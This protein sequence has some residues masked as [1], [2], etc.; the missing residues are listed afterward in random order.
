M[1]EESIEQKAI[2]Y[3]TMRHIEGVR[4][5]IGL[6]VTELLKRAK[7][8]DQE[9]MREPEVGI[10]TLYT[11]KLKGSTYGSPEYK[12]YLREM[13]VALDHHYATYRHHPEFH[14]DCS[15]VPCPV[16]A[17]YEIS[18]SG[19]IRTADTKT[20]RKLEVTPHGYC[21]VQLRNDKNYLVHRLVMMAFKPIDPIG[22]MQVN[23]IN[24]IKHDNRVENLEWVTATENQLHAYE[25]ELKTAN[26]KYVVHCVEYDITTLGV[27]KMAWELQKR[28]VRVCESGIW[29]AINSDTGNHMGL[30]FIG[31]KLVEF[32]PPN[33]IDK[34]NLFDLLEMCC[35][36]L[37]SSRRHTDGNIMKSI[38][39]NRSRFGMDDTLVNVFRNTVNCFYQLEQLGR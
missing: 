9:K 27:Q 10:F 2:N 14:V 25:T 19:A 21:R 20:M 36:W 18:K 1:S 35:D 5:L 37:A 3:D 22:D 26:V 11:P 24:G 15:W 38:E 33:E 13:K 7:E 4:N 39:V 28:G 12:D 16:D 6:S 31:D 8:H 32:N 17:Y 29:R 23:H 30:T 34:M